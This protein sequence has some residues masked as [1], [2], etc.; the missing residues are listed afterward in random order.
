MQPGICCWS[1]VGFIVIC[2]GVSAGGQPNKVARPVA[3]ANERLEL[4]L[5]AGQKGGDRARSMLKKATLRGQV[6]VLTLAESGKVTCTALACPEADGRTGDCAHGIWYASPAGLELV[7]ASGRHAPGLSPATVF[8]RRPTRAPTFA[9]LARTP[10]GILNRAS[11]TNPVAE[12]ADCGP[13]GRISFVAQLE[14]GV[15]GVETSNNMGIWSDQNGIVTLLCRIGDQAPGTPDGA[16]FDGFSHP[17]RD[18][19]GATT[20]VGSLARGRRGVTDQNALGI[21]SNRSGKLEKVVRASEKIADGSQVIEFG[22]GNV[23][24]SLVASNKGR[25]RFLSRVKTAD[26][27]ERFGVCIEYENGNLKM[28]L[29]EGDAMPVASTT[30]G[31]GNLRTP[32]LFRFREFTANGADDYIVRADLQEGPIEHND[33]YC[34]IRDGRLTP[35]AIGPAPGLGPEVAF[36]SCNEVALNDL[37]DVAFAAELSGR[38]VTPENARSVWVSKGDKLKLVAQAMDEVPDITTGA[39]FDGFER[40]FFNNRGQIAFQAKLREGTGGVSRGNSRGIWATD[41]NG[42]LRLIVRAADR[43]PKSA[44]VKG[45]FHSVA[46]AGFNSNGQIVFTNTPDPQDTQSSQL[47]TVFVSD[48]V[49]AVAPAIK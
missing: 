8:A 14:P 13:D 6:S 35:I 19:S 36:H 9:T 26:L 28:V 3:P 45:D 40:L 2:M 11:I 48:A 22:S 7:A 15:G 41:A 27:K 12:T 20:F 24:P 17:R 21:W 46:L 4:V 32:T 39:L 16:P 42:Q 49:A 37:G 34:L 31:F 18:A 44:K 25:C 30:S 23:G 38:E 5:R 47:Y 29:C 1:I 10:A 43:I 33:V